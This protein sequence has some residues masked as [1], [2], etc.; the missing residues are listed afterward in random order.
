M[1]GLALG[2]FAWYLRVY[3]QSTTQNFSLT[4]QLLLTLN[5]MSHFDNISQ[6][7][8]SLHWLL[9]QFPC[10]LGL[11]SE[12]RVSSHGKLAFRRIFLASTCSAFSFSN[13]FS[14]LVFFG[15]KTFLLV[16]AISF[17]YLVY[18]CQQWL[19]YL[20]VTMH[21]PLVNAIVTYV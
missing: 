20:N 9:F 6:R 14:L 15:K 8:S 17:A 16:S 1:Q 7:L 4:R 10:F 3:F 11:I 21:G 2:F 18:A 19:H 12:F 5:L 13:L